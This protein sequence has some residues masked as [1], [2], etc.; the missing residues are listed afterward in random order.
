MLKKY[1]ILPIL[2]TLICLLPVFAFSAASSLD[3]ITNTKYT[4]LDGKTKDIKDLKGKVFLLNFWA[5][6]CAPC[7]M[8]VPH[9][10]KV[11]NEYN[12]KG[13]ELLSLSVDSQFGLTKIKDISNKAKMKYLLG[14]ASMDTINELNI[15]AIP[16]SMLF[17]KDGKVIQ[18][19]RG[20]PDTV[21]LEKA[22]TAALQK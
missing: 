2:I 3:G 4:A 11:Y 7:M 12:S 6:W 17:G 16:T 21:T 15:F 20:P 5:S 8:E 14:K 13:F 18:T 9:L 1:K 19:F 10:N 22:I